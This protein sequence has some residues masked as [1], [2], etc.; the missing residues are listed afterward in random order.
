MKSTGSLDNNDIDINQ[1]ADIIYEDI[2]RKFV[3][4]MAP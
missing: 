1:L 2:T 3:I 4:Y